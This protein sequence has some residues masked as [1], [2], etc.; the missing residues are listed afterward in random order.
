[1]QE[2]IKGRG[3]VFNVEKG[4]SSGY[5]ESEYNQ[6]CNSR[7]IKEGFHSSYQHQGGNCVKGK[8]PTKSSQNW[9]EHKEHE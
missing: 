9:E 5:L 4:S 3:E 2:D 8:E 1:M 7:R 6:G